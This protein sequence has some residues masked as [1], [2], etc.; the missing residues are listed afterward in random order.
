MHEKKWS[1]ML[2]KIHSR[3][4]LFHAKH[5]FMLNLLHSII[6]EFLFMTHENKFA[7][8]YIPEL[9]PSCSPEPTT[10]YQGC[11]SFTIHKYGPLFW[12]TFLAFR[13]WELVWIRSYLEW[14]KIQNDIFYCKVFFFAS[15]LALVISFI[16]FFLKNFWPNLFK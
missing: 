6:E 16:A 7:H 5:K 3:G 2:H 11:V 4:F 10:N 13:K 15:M 12:P 14:L 1:R 8:I 9:Y